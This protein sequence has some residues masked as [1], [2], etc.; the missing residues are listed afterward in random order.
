M[1]AGHSEY[2]S[3]RERDALKAFVDR[4]GRLAIF[5]GNTCFW[6]VRWED[7]GRTLVCHKWKGF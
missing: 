5:S 7:E 6:K 2:W 1:L 4:G 3:G